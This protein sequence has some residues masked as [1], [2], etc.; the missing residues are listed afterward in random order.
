MLIECDV[1]EYYVGHK[2]IISMEIYGFDICVW[3]YKAGIIFLISLLVVE[4]NL[5]M[6]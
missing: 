3:P 2:L 5:E 6:S 4:W 1:L